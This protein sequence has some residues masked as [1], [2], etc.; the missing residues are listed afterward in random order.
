MKLQLHLSVSA[1]L[2]NENFERRRTEVPVGLKTIFAS[3]YCFF[4]FFWCV[5]LTCKKKKREVLDSKL[6]ATMAQCGECTQ[7]MRD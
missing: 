3:L 4:F 7:A 1:Q 2:M 5:S 6:T